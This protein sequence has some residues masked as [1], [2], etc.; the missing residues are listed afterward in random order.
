MNQQSVTHWRAFWIEAWRAALNPLNRCKTWPGPT[1]A[2]L[3]LLS[4]SRLT[5]LWS[6]TTFQVGNLDSGWIFPAM[7]EHGH[8]PGFLTLTLKYDDFWTCAFLNSAGIGSKSIKPTGWLC[9]PVQYCEVALNPNFKQN[10][11]AALWRFVFFFFIYVYSYQLK[12]KK[13]EQHTWRM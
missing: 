1:P 9:S 4:S 2:L 3:G 5:L 8:L 6:P 11:L 10:P 12:N 13:S 7:E